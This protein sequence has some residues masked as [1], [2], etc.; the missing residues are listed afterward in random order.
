M[1]RDM[2]V[3]RRLAD[4]QF[5]VDADS[6]LERAEDRLLASVAGAVGE[7]PALTLA[8][9]LLGAGLDAAELELLSSLMIERRMAK[10]EVVFRRGDPG[11]AM[12]VSLQG[13][14]GIWLP[15]GSGAGGTGRA[16][17]MVSYA[18]GVAFGEMGLLQGRPR[19]ADAIAEQD[20]LVLELPLAGYERIVTE[21][22]T[23]LSKM[24]LNLGLLLSSRVR[25]LTDELEALHGTR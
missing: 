3:E 25:A 7:P 14:I 23:L 24:L 17:R 19:S 5:F 22:P 6:A 18:P 13:Q 16:R 4:A 1:I 11:D 15:A 20:A 8:Q 2:D 21:N 10:G 12:Y 9:T